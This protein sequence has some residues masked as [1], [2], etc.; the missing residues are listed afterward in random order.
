MKKL[1]FTLLLLSSCSTAEV[2]ETA[3]LPSFEATING[4]Q[5]FGIEGSYCGA[6]MCVDKISPIDQNLDYSEYRLKEGDELI[7]KVKSSDAFKTLQF[8]LM[9]SEG[10][11]L[12]DDLMVEPQAEDGTYKIIDELNGDLVILTAW[13]D[14]ENGDMTYY[15]PF[16]I[17][18]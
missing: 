15:F 12:D 10:T 16:T 17:E 5:I 13:G 8:S 14:F 9:D 3:T 7:V 4:E 2:P 1:I 18:N 6:T 11:I